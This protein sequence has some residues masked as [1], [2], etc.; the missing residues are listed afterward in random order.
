MDNFNTTTE[1]L[2]LEEARERLED[3]RPLVKRMMDLTSEARVIR[4]GPLED[5]P[6][7]EQQKLSRLLEEIHEDFEELILELN[8]LGAI[9]KDPEKGL[10]DFYSW[11][12]GE[13]AFLCWCW[14]EETIG[15]W[16]GIKEGFSGRTAIKE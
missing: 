15:H 6:A 16:H 11:I 14:G 10:I 3:V 13:L 2:T 1:V 12:E 4:D 5:A 9:L 7:G 8:G